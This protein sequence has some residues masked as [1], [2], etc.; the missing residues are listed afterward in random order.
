MKEWRPGSPE[1]RHK[2]RLFQR[3]DTGRTF[4]LVD[5]LSGTVTGVCSGPTESG[6]CPHAHA[7]VVPCEGRRIFP[8]SGTAGRGL[9]FTVRSPGEGQCPMAWLCR[10]DD[11]AQ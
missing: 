2:R 3:A 1:R 10:L 9:P 5:T 4:L 7:G 11:A 8:I 6:L